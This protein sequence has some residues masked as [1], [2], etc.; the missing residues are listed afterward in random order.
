MSEWI[1]CSDRLPE[2]NQ[3]V[4]ASDGGDIEILRFQQTS[5]KRNKTRAG[6]FLSLR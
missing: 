5:D 2:N 3:Y 1:K 6:G 4:I